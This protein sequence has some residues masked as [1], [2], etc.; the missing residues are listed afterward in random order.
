[1]DVTLINTIVTWQK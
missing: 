1:M